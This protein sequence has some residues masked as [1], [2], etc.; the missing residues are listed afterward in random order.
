MKASSLVANKALKSDTV[1]GLWPVTA[2]LSSN[3]S[4]YF[5]GVFFVPAKIRFFNHPARSFYM[6]KGGS[7]GGGRSGGGAQ[8]GG[9]SGGGGGGSSGGRGQGNGGG[10]PSGT[11]NP[12]GGGRSNAPAGGGKK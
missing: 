10:W 2:P 3:V 6:S 9:R 11:G 4:Q 1:S 12:S 7:T 5:L 8:G